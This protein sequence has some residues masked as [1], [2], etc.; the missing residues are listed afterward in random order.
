MEIRKKKIIL[1]SLLVFVA[2]LL[3]IFTLNS[4]QSKEFQEQN[5]NGV[6]LINTDVPHK[7]DIKDIIETNIFPDDIPAITN[8]EFSEPSDIDYLESDALGIGVNF[9]GDQRFYP[10]QVL[11]WHSVINDEVG[12]KKILVSYCAFCASSVVYS[13][14][15]DGQ[16]LEFKASTKLWKD[17]LLIRDISPDPSLWSSL[18]GES[19][20]GKYNSTKLELLESE[21]TTFAE[22]VEKYPKT[23][24]LNSDTGFR[25]PY[26]INVLKNENLYKDFQT[27]N[28]DL[29]P[30]I[31]I[32]FAEYDGQIYGASY[33][34]LL[35]EE[36]VTITIDKNT[37]ISFK[38]CKD[39]ISA[40]LSDNEK[41]VF[42][43]LE[44]IAS[45]FFVLKAI[46]PSSVISL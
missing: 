42:T 3:T 8:P 6:I 41:S 5:F 23:K 32:S 7:G 38:Y 14:E 16:D 4:N 2:L 25:R 15:V 29:D 19:I 36:T 37:Q 12:N 27:E 31:F 24:V 43:E 1:S 30:R 11:I 20:Y 10:N 39:K 28:L 26:E 13:R 45:P 21:N 33:N 9:N 40:V 34:R 35:K 18:L 17:N 46:Y 44:T 22:W